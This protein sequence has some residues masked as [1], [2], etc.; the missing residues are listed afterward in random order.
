MRF[1]VLGVRFVPLAWFRNATFVAEYL[2]EITK[3]LS[4][5]AQDNLVIIERFL[6]A[7]LIE[8]TAF[9]L[10]QEHGYGECVLEHSGARRAE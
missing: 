6:F 4:F 8:M 9:L 5:R 7:A 1:H 3:I 10:F 2:F